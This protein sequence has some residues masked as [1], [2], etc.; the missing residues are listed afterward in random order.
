MLGTEFWVMAELRRLASLGIYAVLVRRGDP[1]RG[2]IILSI[3]NPDYRIM[4]Y[5]IARNSQLEYVWHCV[6]SEPV[7]EAMAVAL[8]DKMIMRDP[9]VWVIEIQSSDNPCPL[10][11]LDHT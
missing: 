6:N 4:L 1:A 5:E 8:L 3:V 7:T 9:D 11:L 2:M 10:P